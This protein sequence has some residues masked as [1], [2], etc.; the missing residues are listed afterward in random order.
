MFQPAD[1]TRIFAVGELL[2]QE[3]EIGPGR[4]FRIGHEALLSFS[5]RCQSG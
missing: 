5:I 4:E 3:L 1:L 2:F